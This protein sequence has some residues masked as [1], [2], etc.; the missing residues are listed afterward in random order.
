[1]LGHWTPSCIETVKFQRETFVRVLEVSLHYVT[2]KIRFNT[3]F[4]DPQKMRFGLESVQRPSVKSAKNHPKQS[5]ALS[6]V[7]MEDTRIV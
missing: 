5:D 6:T 2:T 4:L 7:S 1:M 3:T